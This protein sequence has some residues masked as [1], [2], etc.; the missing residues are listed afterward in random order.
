MDAPK[1]T[2]S[3]LI[4]V[5]LFF[6]LSLK[7]K[8]FFYRIMIYQYTPYIGNFH[9]RA[10]SPT[11]RKEE[12]KTKDRG[13]EKTITKDGDK[14]RGRDKVRKRRSASTGSSSSRFVH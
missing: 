5:L 4:E 11:K 10:P 9:S 13:K 2:Q 7:K 8:N 1:N 14:E 6:P 3:A 12:E